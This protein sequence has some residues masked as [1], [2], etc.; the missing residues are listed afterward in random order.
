MTAVVLVLLAVAAV[1][2][3]ASRSGAPATAVVL[4]VLAVTAVGVLLQRGGAA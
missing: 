4:G 3:L 2:M 1:G